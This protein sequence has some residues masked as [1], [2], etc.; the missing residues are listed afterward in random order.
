MSPIICVSRMCLLP[1]S[2]VIWCAGGG[3]IIVFLFTCVHGMLK[4]IFSDKD[5]CVIYSYIMRHSFVW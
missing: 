2:I 1:I 5:P 3:D 4:I